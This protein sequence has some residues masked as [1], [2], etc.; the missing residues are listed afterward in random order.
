MAV[1]TKNM[2]YEI[3]QLRHSLHC[4][5]AQDSITPLGT[6]LNQCS[7]LDARIS[8]ILGLLILLCVKVLMQPFATDTTFLKKFFGLNTSYA[9][10]VSLFSFSP[11]VAGT[12]TNYTCPKNHVLSVNL[13]HIIT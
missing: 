13:G 4:A 7:L 12:V 1:T 3:S 6:E 11:A 5:S 8:D 9:T 10:N 2:A